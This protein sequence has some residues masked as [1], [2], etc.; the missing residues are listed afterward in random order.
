MLGIGWIGGQRGAGGK[1][2][3]G[4]RGQEVKHSEPYCHDRRITL[5]VRCVLQG[6]QGN[7]MDDAKQQAQE[8]RR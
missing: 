3:F 5:G 1:E 6:S 2:E 4:K 8:D 7:R